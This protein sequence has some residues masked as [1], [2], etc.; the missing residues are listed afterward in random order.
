MQ[1]RKK[2]LM[3]DE[4]F[5][6]ANFLIEKGYNNEN[7]IVEISV[8]DENTLKRVNEDFFYKY[9]G[10]GEPDMDSDVSFVDINISGVKFRYKVKSDD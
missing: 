10:E 5:E 7:I 9:G 1:L 2:L 6:I 8:D 4:L 3:G